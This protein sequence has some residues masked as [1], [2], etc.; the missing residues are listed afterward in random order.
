MFFPKCFHV[1]LFSSC[2]NETVQNPVRSSSLQ[3]DFKQASRRYNK[4]KKKPHSSHTERISRGFSSWCLFFRLRV[5]AVKRPPARFSPN[6]RTSRLWRHPTRPVWQW[7]TDVTLTSTTWS[8]TAAGCQDE[9]LGPDA[10]AG[11]LRDQ[12]S[13]YLSFSLLA[14]QM[15][16]SQSPECFIQTCQPLLKELL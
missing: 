8:L 7:V 9:A 16:I 6:S 15:C 4:K 13:E 10:G 11:Q 12:P 5:R 2:P 3:Q 14:P 1:S